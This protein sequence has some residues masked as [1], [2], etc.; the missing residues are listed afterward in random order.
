MIPLKT[1]PR[2]TVFVNPA[3]ITYV[4]TRPN[5]HPSM[6]ALVH[7]VGGH[8]LTVTDPPDVVV[9]KMLPAKDAPTKPQS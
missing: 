6:G 9:R 4:T 8:I 5:S 3:N 7:F 2:E 1:S